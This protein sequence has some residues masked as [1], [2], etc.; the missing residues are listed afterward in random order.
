[1][2]PYDPGLKLPTQDVVT[3]IVALV[4]GDSYSHKLSAGASLSKLGKKVGYLIQACS[5]RCLS[6]TYCIID[7]R[8]IPHSDHHL[9]CRMMSLCKN[10]LMN[11]SAMTYRG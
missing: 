8:A 2:N 4:I 7:T 11:P 6:T 9:A 5:S 1:M 10:I 3:C